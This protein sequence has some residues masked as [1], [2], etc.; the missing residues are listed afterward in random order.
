MFA[1][2][3][4]EPNRTGQISRW[5]IPIN[6]WLDIKFQAGRDYQAGAAI[7][8]MTEDF[9]T[10]GPEISAELANKEWG[11]PG[12]LEFTGP[13]K[14]GEAALKNARKKKELELAGYLSSADHSWASLKGVAGF[15]AMMVG[16]LSHPLDF[17]L[18]FLPVVGSAAKAKAAAQAGQGVFRQALA[19][20]VLTEEALAMFTQFPKFSASVIDGTIGNAI[21]E[22]PVFIQKTRDQ[23]EYG[24]GD[25]ALN[26]AGGGVFAGALH[27]GFR[28][29][30]RAFD[31]LSPEIKERIK[32]HEVDAFLKS[33][34]PASHTIAKVDEEAIAAK[35]EEDLRAEATRIVANDIAGIKAALPKQDLLFQGVRPGNLKGEHAKSSYLTDDLSLA[36]GFTAREGEAGDG[37]ID[38]YDPAHLPPKEQM[39][40]AEKSKPGSNVYSYVDLANVRPIGHIT[41]EGNQYVFHESPTANTDTRLANERE[42]RIREY[43]DS[44]KPER[45]AT[46]K[47]AELQAQMAQGKILTAEQVKEFTMASDERSASVLAEDAKNIEANL[48]SELDTKLKDESLTPE[49]KEALQAEL[50]E[51][52]GQVDEGLDDQS[53]AI[54]QAHHCLINNG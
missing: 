40:E 46:A 47:A 27:V 2:S 1:F 48:K 50:D 23:A 8:R 16:N 35:V 28:G 53:K 7:S 26:I 13:V 37:R 15:G 36:E 52:L 29:L 14:V 41:K 9:I 22:I 20:G 18:M 43:I 54:D 25:A 3:Q 19:R 42:Q 34:T 38:V 30:Q 31:R 17:G 44:R 6:R 51:V 45:I 32:E 24:L 4:I 10:E 21:A 33:E 49:Q 12:H 39:L 5:D 11:I